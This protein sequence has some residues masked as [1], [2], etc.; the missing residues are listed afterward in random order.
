MATRCGDENRLRSRRDRSRRLR[1]HPRKV[2]VALNAVILSAAHAALLEIGVPSRRCRD[3]SAR[4]SREALYLRA[5]RGPRASHAVSNGYPARRLPERVKA[6]KFVVVLVAHDKPP[7]GQQ[8]RLY[9]DCASAVKAESLRAARLVPS[10]K[11]VDYSCVRSTRCFLW[12]I[13]KRN[14]IL[15]ILRVE[16][17]TIVL[18]NGS[19]MLVKSQ[20]A[21]W[22]RSPAKIFDA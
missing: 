1:H 21:V 14:E 12:P 22:R 3:R 20:L 9:P 8:G 19:D 18:E 11:G 4:A 2:V 15:H 5:R 17:K 6:G 13:H 16:V 7:C 10:E